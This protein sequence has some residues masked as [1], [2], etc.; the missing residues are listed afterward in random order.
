MDTIFNHI[1]ERFNEKKPLT[2]EEL[3]KFIQKTFHKDV[4]LDSLRHVIR[5][6]GHFKIVTG[7]PLEKERTEVSNEEIDKF[8]EITEKEIVDIPA[9]F[10]FNADETGIQ[11]FLDIRDVTCIVPI[12]YPKEQVYVP[13][14]RKIKR[15]TMLS[16]VCG[17]GESLKPLLVLQ[18]KTI[19]RELLYEGING[20]DVECVCTENGFMLSNLFTHLRIKF[21]F[22]YLSKKRKKLNYYGEA[23]LILDNCS[24]HLSDEFLDEC[25][26][27]KVI[28]NFI[29]AYSSD[30]LQ[31]LD[32]GLFGIHT[33]KINEE[34]L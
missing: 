16:C 30:Q 5:N 25:L 29:P 21:I 33:F 34:Y 27:H 2:Y 3:L 13:V 6:N 1:T 9:S 8:F 20:D 18:R 31:V 4:L 19:E 7:I 15:T 17:D 23:M 28:V 10:L 11:P 26:Y 22:P 12:E 32:L 14:D 24:S